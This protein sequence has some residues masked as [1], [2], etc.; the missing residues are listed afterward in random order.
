MIETVDQ[1][2]PFGRARH[3]GDGVEP[4][5][6]GRV[7]GRR[8]LQGCDDLQEFGGCNPRLAAAIVGQQDEMS[9]SCHEGERCIGRDVKVTGDCWRTSNSSSSLLSCRLPNPSRPFGERESP[10]NVT[11]P[12]PSSFRVEPLSISMTVT[13]SRSRPARYSAPPSVLNNTSSRAPFTEDVVTTLRRS[14]SRPREV[15]YRNDPGKM[16][17]PPALGEF[18]APVASIKRRTAQ[19]L[20]TACVRCS[21]PPLKPGGNVAR[22]NHRGTLGKPLAG[23]T[24]LSDASVVEYI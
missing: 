19:S 8:A 16:V 18:I 14:G 22:A 6:V 3:I 21:A 5:T 11:S 23:L 24:S 20:S 15:V 4:S 10:V 9:R 17:T 1:K 13:P 2:A 7:H 12:P